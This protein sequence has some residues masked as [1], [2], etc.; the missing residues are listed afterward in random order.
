MLLECA[1]NTKCFIKNRLIKYEIK[2]ISLN[3]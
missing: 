1:I 3:T 2:H